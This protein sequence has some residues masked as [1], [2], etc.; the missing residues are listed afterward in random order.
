MGKNLSMILVALLGVFCI[1]VSLTNRHS[2]DTPSIRAAGRQDSP[3][4][5]AGTTANAPSVA[6]P[7]QRSSAD[8]A[9]NAEDTSDVG[10]PD[11]IGNAFRPTLDQERALR[12]LRNYARGADV[13]VP[14]DISGPE[15]MWSDLQQLAEVY[16]L[17]MAESKREF[18]ARLFAVGKQ[19]L[20]AGNANLEPVAHIPGSRKAVRARPAYQGEKVL[21]V[22]K[23]GGHFALRLPPGQDEKLD[24]LATKVNNLRREAASD[25]TRILQ[26]YGAIPR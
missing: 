20:A 8:P 22:A 10:S 5:I 18:N 4:Q 1:A 7:L 25:L 3:D 21:M 19:A 15:S 17:G 16:R 2:D 24:E 26:M 23:E 6:A 9:I 11:V 12:T 13:K 14:A